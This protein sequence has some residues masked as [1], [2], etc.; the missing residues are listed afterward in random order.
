LEGPHGIYDDYCSER[1]QNVVV[2]R[3]ALFKGVRRLFRE[4]R[5]TSAEFFELEQSEG[6][7]IFVAKYSVV[8][9]WKTGMTPTAENVPQ[10][11]P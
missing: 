2:Y 8:K 4:D 7:Q 6:Q 9:F 5:D 10:K 11:L 3:N 1:N